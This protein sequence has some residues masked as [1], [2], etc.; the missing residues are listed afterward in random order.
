M[1]PK[2]RVTRLKLNHIFENSNEEVL[3]KYLKAIT[4]SFGV[5]QLLLFITKYSKSKQLD[6]M[7]HIISKKQVK[8]KQHQSL[9]SINTNYLDKLPIEC[10]REIIQYLDKESVKS[11]KETSRLNAINCIEHMRKYSIKIINGGQALNNPKG[12]G[13]IDSFASKS[14]YS[15][16]KSMTSLKTNL[17]SKLGIPKENLLIYRSEGRY[18]KSLS[19]SDGN[20][21]SGYKGRLN[22]HLVLDNRKLIL[23]NHEQDIDKWRIMNCESSLRYKDYKLLLL[24]YFD[25]LKQQKIMVQY[26]LYKENM[27]TGQDLFDYIEHKFIEI[28]GIDNKWYPQ[29]LHKLK[30]MNKDPEVLKLYV[31]GQRSKSGTLPKS[32]VC[33]VS[34]GR[35]MLTFQLNPNH[36]SFEDI[37]DTNILSNFPLYCNRYKPICITMEIANKETLIAALQNYYDKKL[38]EQERIVFKHELDS[39]LNFVN[40]DDFQL[41]D[42]PNPYHIEI[43]RRVEKYL[44]NIIHRKYFQILR[45]L[46]SVSKVPRERYDYDSNLQCHIIWH[47]VGITQS[48]DPH[49]P[50]S[51]DSTFNYAFYCVK[52]FMPNQCP[53]PIQSTYYKPKEM[54]FWYHKEFVVR[55]FINDLFRTI[56][57]SQDHIFVDNTF[58]QMADLFLGDANEEDDVDLLQDDCIGDS[59]R[60]ILSLWPQFLAGANWIRKL[61][62]FDLNKVYKEDRME[63]IRPWDSRIQYEDYFKRS[64]ETTTTFNLYMIGIKS[65]DIARDIKLMIQF[66]AWRKY[67]WLDEHFGKRVGAP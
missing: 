46:G 29:F 50:I 33:N 36:P 60:C 13:N 23:F 15:A 59:V 57:N 51:M 49:S 56:R 54:K 4:N 3:N 5:K 28:D 1:S 41:W 39:V 66:E 26:I 58:E 30:Q 53:Y 24:Q 45:H 6:Q 34:P 7:Y 14:R 32:A 37:I 55:D 35:G 65:M 44:G 64:N 38:D 27:M 20:I 11:F 52:I 10:N 19:W 9:S 31:F 12:R 63:Y 47:N 22:D 16:K 21:M 43:L 17:A 40:S 62:S 25:V 18:Y 67:D 61:K 42:V 8:Y 2:L 48:F